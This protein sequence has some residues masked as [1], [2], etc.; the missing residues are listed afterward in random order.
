MNLGFT[1]D[2]LR[3]EKEH[4][5]SRAIEAEKFARYQLTRVEAER[6]RADGERERADMEQKRADMEQ[7][8][9]D[10][11][12]DRVAK[13]GVINSK[14]V[15]SAETKRHELK[16]ATETVDALNAKLAAAEAASDASK[17]SVCTVQ[18][19]M[20]DMEAL[21]AITTGELAV[22]NNEMGRLRDNLDV[23]GRINTEEAKLIGDL[24]AASETV[25]AQMYVLEGKYAHTTG[26]LAY[27]NNEVGRLRYNLDVVCETNKDLLQKEVKY[28]ADLGEASKRYSVLKEHRAS[29]VALGQHWRLER[30]EARRERDAAR[31]ELETTKPTM[32][33]LETSL[34]ASVAKEAQLQ[35]NLGITR[36]SLLALDARRE[37]LLDALMKEQQR[38]DSAEEALAK[39]NE[40]L[41]KAQQRTFVGRL[42]D[43]AVRGIGALVASVG[44][45]GSVALSSVGNAGSVALSSVLGKRPAD[46]VAVSADVRDLVSPRKR[47]C[48]SFAARG[49]DGA[50]A[51]DN[52]A[53]AVDAVD[54]LAVDAVDDLD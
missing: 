17:A 32:A 46:D 48:S 23:V 29:A 3:Q 37:N 8:R 4:A 44:N 14:D 5:E 11:M 30:N 53:A 43:S 42:G 47:G 9:A 16:R 38:A 25:E 33:A 36:E 50:A 1:T 13:L 35:H 34:A 40:A 22:A 15:I 39:A 51:V 54:D 6:K 7:R 31:A 12:Y 49:G 41:A 45:A 24:E 2:V 19:K 21:H 20:D 28:I 26:E 52:G 18:A 27:A 10:S